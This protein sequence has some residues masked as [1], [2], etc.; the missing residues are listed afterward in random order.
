ML[1]PNTSPTFLPWEDNDPVPLWNEIFGNDHPLALEI[2]CK[3]KIG[4]GLHEA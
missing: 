4:V 1:I 3:V 2:G